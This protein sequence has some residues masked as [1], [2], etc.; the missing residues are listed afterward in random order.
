MPG[1]VLIPW[2][3]CRSYWQED[4]PMGACLTPQHWNQKYTK[5]AA[6]GWWTCSPRAP[7]FG[8]VKVMLWELL[9]CTAFAPVQVQGQMHGC[10]LSSID[11]WGPVWS[12]PKWG[13]QKNCQDNCPGQLPWLSPGKDQ[14]FELRDTGFLASVSLRT[15]RL[16]LVWEPSKWYPGQGLLLSTHHRP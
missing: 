2:V 14:A 16:G 1:E 12:F 8:G 15:Q 3:A 13:K 10:L 6:L 5:P 9:L 4:R 7:R 11:I